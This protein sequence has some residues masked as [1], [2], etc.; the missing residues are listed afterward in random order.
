M[1]RVICDTCIWYYLGDKTL[2]FDPD[3]EFELCCTYLNMWELITSN[4]LITNFKKIQN[5]CKAIIE[6]C[7]T[8]ILS[9]PF[10]HLETLANNKY[11][12]EVTELFHII[13]YIA[14]TDKDEFLIDINNG[15]L[16]NIIVQKSHTLNNFFVEQ[17][18]SELIEYKNMLSKQKRTLKVQAKTNKIRIMSVDFQKNSIINELKNYNSL[19]NIDYI[20]ENFWNNLKFYFESRLLFFYN[21]KHS[22]EMKIYKNDAVDLLNLV[23]VNFDCLYW[24]EE[25]KW[26]NIFKEAQLDSFLYQQISK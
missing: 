6:H 1:K 13:E 22:S 15:V 9:S 25:R 4:N 11:Y 26:N 24:T 14:N 17:I 20:D 3:Q 12:H 10:N 21:Y 19:F 2:H 8:F 16:E 18:T 7:N 5:A 23:Y